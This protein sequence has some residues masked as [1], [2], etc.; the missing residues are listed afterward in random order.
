LTGEVPGPTEGEVPFVADRY[1]HG[2]PLG[3]GSR[4]EFER[5]LEGEHCGEAGEVGLDGL[6][7]CGRH[8]DRLRLRERVAYWRAILAHVDLWSGEARRRDRGDVVGLLEVERAGASA[9]LERTS[10]ALQ[11]N[12]EGRI[13]DGPGDEVGE[14]GDGPPR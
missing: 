13:P 6:W 8:A 14:G 2:G 9:A 7:L 5:A 4:C 11:R 1:I 10:E 12:R 3:V